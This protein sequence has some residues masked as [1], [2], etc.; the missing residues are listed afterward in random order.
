MKHFST[1][2]EKTSAYVIGILVLL[3]LLLVV[4]L[5]PISK[6]LIQKYDQRYL[7][8]EVTLKWVYINPFSG[9][10]YISN[11]KILEAN[12]D[13][14]FFSA[15]EVSVK[16]NVFKLFSRTIAISE[17]NIHKPV[18]V[19]EQDRKLFNFNDL[20]KRFSS[21]DSLLQEGKE[22]FR[23]NI[24][25][26]KIEDGTFY[27]RERS[28]PVNYFV[29][30]VHIDSEGKKWNSD[31]IAAKISLISG[32][33]T[34]SVKGEISLNIKSLD[35]RLR[36]L[37]SKF[38]L[39]VLEQYL[40]NITDYGSLTANL[41][42]DVTASGNFK[43]AENLDARGFVAINDLHFGKNE[44]DDYASFKKLSISAIRLSPK[45]KIY[46][47]DSLSLVQPYFKYERYDRLDN[48]QNM[49]GKKGRKIREAK[50]DAESPNVLFQIA[51]YVKLLVKNFFKSNFEINRV[52]LY[53]GNVRY[54][55]F[56][57]TEKF[58]IAAQPLN[59]RVDSIRRSRKWV[60]LTFTTL[61]K[62]YGK[63][64]VNLSVNPK[65]TSDFSLNYHFE[66]IPAAL[67][68]PYLISFTSFPVDRGTVEIKGAWIVN[69]G[70]IQS[71]NHLIII[72]PRL[73]NRQKR[74][75]ARWVPLKFFMFFAREPGNVIDYEVPI[76]GN[77]NNPKFKLKDVLVDAV[78]NLFLKPPTSIYRS[79]V[80]VF[81]NEIEKSFALNWE[82]RKSIL[83][84]NQEKFVDDLT[85]YLL[86]NPLARISITP[87]VYSEKEKEYIL[88][89]EAKKWY[90][91]KEHQKTA[92]G[93]GLKDS[94]RIEKMSIKDSLVMRYLKA[95]VGSEQLN[96]VQERCMMLVGSD[97]IEADFRELNAE[98]KKVFLSYFSDDLKKRIKFNA[99]MNTIPF[100]GFS[101]YKIEY[102]GDWPDELRE[103][104]F[105]ML[106]LNE[107]SPRKRYKREV[108]THLKKGTSVITNKP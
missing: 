91:I 104:Y 108:L 98:R 55:D 43:K 66:K 86:E 29:K 93:L 30:D 18:G 11:L 13:S 34:G 23:F 59:V 71:H 20:I 106:D 61:L 14:V 79:E 54:L 49:F 92:G 31:T 10:A 12:G 68:N 2:F 74:S 73:N 39:S 50:A 77:L 96:T 72:D 37:I 8:R 33:G 47:F 1:S 52:A 48:L 95:R 22:P 67:F 58:E 83:Q 56:S 3:A 4:F 102:N 17:L 51:D 46:M 82:M 28:I 27:Y 76:L 5:S 41:D 6:Y 99:P 84:P 19:I 42:A 38:D 97:K 107:R 63:V 94:S 90:Y 40:K 80:R 103:A 44:A 45:G 7:G 53:N 81:E 87:M 89:F 57:L 78:S 101:Y 70:N 65:D 21:G 85:N 25:H 32:A 26:I 88:F 60:N 9:Y 16:I 100:N 62:P 24:A 105:A 15:D 35:Y 36:A 64:E 69:N 75:G